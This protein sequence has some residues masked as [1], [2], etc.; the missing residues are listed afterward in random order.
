M[1]TSGDPR[2]VR[3]V[4][5]TL[6]I[7]STLQ[8]KDRAG[9]TELA[10]DLDRSKGTIH[11][12]LTTLSENEHVV[13]EDDKYRLSLRYLE[14]GESVRSQ[15]DGYDIVQEE[16]E[17]LANKTGELAQFA[18]NEHGQI[19]YMC[20]SPGENAVQTASSVG[21]REYMHCNSL[22]KAIL[23]NMAESRVDEI[24]DRHGLPAFTD[25]T[26]TSREELHSELETVRERGYAFDEEELIEGI[27]CVGA[28]IVANDE[29][30]GAISI[31]G[32]STRMEGE[33]FRKEFPQMVTRSANVIEINTKFA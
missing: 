27:R 19:V 17:D 15:I 10:T 24:I 13:K 2:T 18:T 26:I 12:H 9:V 4:Q 33:Q 29:I 31:S 28:P 1:E 21:K 32:P 3:A 11:S 7:I 23:A 25:Q 14:L 20:K 16:A 22:G 30:F 6:D 8:E 5:T